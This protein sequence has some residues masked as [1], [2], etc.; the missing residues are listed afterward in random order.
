MSKYYGVR[1]LTRDGILIAARAC[2]RTHVE[3]PNFQPKES[4]YQK[5]R[6]VYRL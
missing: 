2:E 4:E 6:K 5:K 3:K 1:T